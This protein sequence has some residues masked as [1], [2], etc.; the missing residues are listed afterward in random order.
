MGI[1]R[2][3]TEVRSEVGVDQEAHSARLKE[4]DIPGAEIRYDKRSRSYNAK[5]GQIRSVEMVA[6]WAEMC[7]AFHRAKGRRIVPGERSRRESPPI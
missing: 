2:S 4:L 5:A 6:A 1:D 7:L 3:F